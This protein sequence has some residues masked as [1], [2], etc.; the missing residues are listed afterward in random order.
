MDR[1]LKILVVAGGVLI[2]DQITKIMVLERLHLHERL[3]VITGFL[4]LTHVQNTGMAFGLL[5]GIESPWLRWALVGVAVVAVTII[6]SYARQGASRAA[7]AVPFGAILGGALGNLL[8]RLRLGYVVDFI[9]AHWNGWQWPA[10]NVADAAIT[11]GGIALFLTLAAERN[12]QETDEAATAASPEVSGIDSV[13]PSGDAETE[14][15]EAD[16]AG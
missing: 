14:A 10:F 1:T 3:T 11:M 5:R 13:A 4:D 15:D 2:V 7:V 6:W 12:P 16:E 8:D 9:L